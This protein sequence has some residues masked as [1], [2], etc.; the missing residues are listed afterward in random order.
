MEITQTTSTSERD[1]GALTHLLSFAG[2]AIPFGSIVGPLV[3]WLMKKDESE[4]LD[5][6][7]RAVLNFQISYVI[8][9][10]VAVILCFVLIGFPIL[11]VLPILNVIFTIIGAVKAR[12]GIVWNYPMT[13]KFLG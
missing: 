5:Q 12:D 6:T 8:W 3:I 1:L 2:F 4:F 10:I 7:G 13:I 11:F 9:T